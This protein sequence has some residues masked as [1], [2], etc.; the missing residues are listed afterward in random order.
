MK[1]ILV[2]LLAVAFVNALERGKISSA[3]T[4]CKNFH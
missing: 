2:F 3:V 1:R 4:I